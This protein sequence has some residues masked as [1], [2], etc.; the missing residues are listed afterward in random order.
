VRDARARAR[1]RLKR[2]PKTKQTP[3]SHPAKFQSF[4]REIDTA[5]YIGMVPYCSAPRKTSRPRARARAPPHTRA[6]RL[7]RR[8]TRS[9]RREKN[10]RAASPAR[11]PAA[12]VAPLADRER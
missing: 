8:S 7:P 11:E 9:R 2:S 4:P 3:S 12:R 6:R 1:R 5:M 10:P